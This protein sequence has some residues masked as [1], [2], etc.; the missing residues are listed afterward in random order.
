[1]SLLRSLRRGF[2]IFVVR[3]PGYFEVGGDMLP[4]IAVT[5]R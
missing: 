2:W 3:G 1:M 5:V 4:M